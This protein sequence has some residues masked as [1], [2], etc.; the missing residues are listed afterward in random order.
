MHH[1]EMSV[2]LKNTEKL[3]S[4]WQDGDGNKNISYKY[5]PLDVFQEQFG[6]IEDGD[7]EFRGSTLCWRKE[8]A[9]VKIIIF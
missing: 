7:I 3:C 2:F 6:D 5:C 4:N 1:S 8:D 9:L